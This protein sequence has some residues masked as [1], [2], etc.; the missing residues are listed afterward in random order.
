MNIGD[1]GLNVHLLKRVSSYRVCIVIFQRLAFC[2]DNTEVYHVN[3]DG[4]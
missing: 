4:C 2:K 3:V 1:S